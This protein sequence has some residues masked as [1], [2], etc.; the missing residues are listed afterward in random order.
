MHGRKKMWSGTESNRRHGDFQSPALP[1]E[2]PDHLSK[3]YTYL[4]CMDN[5]SIKN[6]TKKIFYLIII[7]SLKTDISAREEY[8]W[9]YNLEGKGQKQFAA[10]MY[11]DAYEN[12]S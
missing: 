4:F 11:N 1:A 6:L 2:L 5:M 9:T 7:F 8:K 3:D 12:G 10:K